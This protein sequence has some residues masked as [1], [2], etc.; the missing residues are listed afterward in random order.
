MCFEAAS[1]DEIESSTASCADFMARIRC[2]DDVS[3]FVCLENDPFVVYWLCFLEFSYFSEED[4]TCDYDDNGDGRGVDSAQGACNGG[5]TTASIGY[6]SNA[7][8]AFP[9][10]FP[11]FVWR[12]QCGPD[13]SGRRAGCASNGD[14]ITA[15]V[16]L[17][18]P[19]VITF[20]S[21]V[22][23]FWSGALIIVLIKEDGSAGGASKGDANTARIGNASTAI[24]FFSCAS[25]LCLAFSLWA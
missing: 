17:A 16:G 11:C 3:E 14:A 2:S 5:A 18:S 7:V 21:S 24:S 20:F 4:I 6:A 1:L 22:S 25:M 10:V 15:N 12:S 19:V 13:Q 9:P 23:M 8:V